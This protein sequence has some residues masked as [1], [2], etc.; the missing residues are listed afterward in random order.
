MKTIGYFIGG[1]EH[2]KDCAEDG[3]EIACS[4]CEKPGTLGMGWHSEEA[5]RRR[6]EKN[7]LPWP[8]HPGYFEDEETVR[9]GSLSEH[10]R[11]LVCT[12]CCEVFYECPI[13]KMR[14]TR[15]TDGDDD[16]TE[17]IYGTPDA[18]RIPS[19]MESLYKE[20]M[21]A[22]RTKRDP[23]VFDEDEGVRIRIEVNFER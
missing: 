14:V 1:E 12:I 13:F 6:C 15:V 23:V 17:T 8:G 20:A 19:E 3:T 10:E 4:V 11:D 2:C 18:R 16:E 5:C 9:I 7:G 21:Q 22:D